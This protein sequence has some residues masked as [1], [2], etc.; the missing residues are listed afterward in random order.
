MYEESDSNPDDDTG[1]LVHNIMVLISVILLLIT[2]PISWMICFQ[3]VQEYERLVVFRLGKVRKGRAVGPGLCFTLPCTDTNIIVDMR[4]GVH[5]IPTQ[6]ILTKDSVAVTV[7][8]VY[9]RVGDPMRAVCG[10]EDYKTTTQFKAQS[11]IRNVLGMKTLTEILIE[12][13]HLGESMSCS[14]QESVVQNGV[15]I[16]RVELKNVGMPSTMQRTMAAEAE[17]KVKARAKVILSD[18]EGEASARLVDAGGDLSPISVHLRY[19]QAMMKI[20]RPF[21][22]DMMY[23]IPM[24]M[25]IVEKLITKDN[26]DERGDLIKKQ[27]NKAR[28][29]IRTRKRRRVQKARI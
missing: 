13:D 15:T 7:D 2:F 28:Q 10:D 12:R 14:L 17:A 21:E 16:E 29:P 4:T 27:T 20:H 26:Q 3:V 18:A 11:V 5:D 8:A 24:P 22:E 25:E 19:L 23:V 9:Y 6:D 1:G